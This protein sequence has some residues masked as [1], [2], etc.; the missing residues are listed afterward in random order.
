MTACKFREVLQGSARNFRGAR[1]GDLGRGRKS[2]YPE[3]IPYYRSHVF[4]D[5]SVGSKKP[6]ISS[7]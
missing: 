4:R 1:Y 7:P 3:T 5:S 6:T 2:T